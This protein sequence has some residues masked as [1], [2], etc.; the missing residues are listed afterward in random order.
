[1]HLYKQGFFFLSSGVEAGPGGYSHGKAVRVGS[2]GETPIFVT[3]MAENRPLI[4]GMWILTFRHP[5]EPTH[6][7]LW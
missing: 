5:G 1:M 7:F 3:K 2:P 4:S 6:P